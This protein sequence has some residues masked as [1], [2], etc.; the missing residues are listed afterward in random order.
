MTSSV[1][2][3][4]GRS[5]QNVLLIDPI[6]RLLLKKLQFLLPRIPVVQHSE[7]QYDY[8]AVFYSKIISVHDLGVIGVLCH[9]SPSERLM[10]VHW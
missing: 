4:K 5:G 9:K 2:A 7:Q 3:G 1:S 8:L 6:L 10:K